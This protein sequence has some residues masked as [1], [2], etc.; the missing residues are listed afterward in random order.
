MCELWW[1]DLTTCD[2]S[3]S[4]EAIICQ[5]HATEMICPMGDGPETRVRCGGCIRQ[6]YTKIKLCDFW[7]DG[8]GTRMSDG[9]KV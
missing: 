8:L 4:L 3:A 5:M 7:G 2:V 6:L 9:R 1:T